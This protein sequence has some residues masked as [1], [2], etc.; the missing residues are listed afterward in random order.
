MRRVLSLPLLLVAVSVPW[1]AAAR[2]ADDDEKIVGTWER[3][4]EKDKDKKEDKD[5]KDKDK[6]GEIEETW[7]IKKTKGAWSVSGKFYMPGKGEVGN[8]K[9]KDVK[10]A[11]GSL[12]F[13]QEFFKL[14]KGFVSGAT[15]S[16]SAEDDRLDVAF[17]PKKGEATRDNFKRAGDAS[18]VIGTWKTTTS[19]AG[20]SETW[21]IEK[22]K[23]GGLAVRGEW[24]DKNGKV[25]HTF[26]GV[27]VRYFMKELFFNQNFTKA[28]KGFPNFG[29]AIACVA[30]DD[31]LFFVWFNGSRTG[32]GKFKRS[33]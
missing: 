6:Y 31:E 17:K 14:P 4:H 19:K 9:G 2:A 27:N 18:E 7:V 25:T 22:D 29:T 10:F 8:F 1:P 33:K 23:K 16:C 30:R 15:V 13:T 32:K 28:P 12:T 21:F 26:K 24:A 11:N 3:L 20:N 5:K